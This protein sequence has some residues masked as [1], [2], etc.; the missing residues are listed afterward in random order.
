M[1]RQPALA[2]W[3][4][5]LAVQLVAGLV[6]AWDPQPAPVAAH[7]WDKA[8]HAIAFAL[9]AGTAAFA[10]PGHWRAAAAGLLAYGAL[11]EIGQAFI[12]GRSC[13]AADLLA[14]GVGVA[15]GLAAVHLLRRLL[16]SLR[17][18]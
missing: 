16:S 9:M 4:L 18:G 11:V 14:D 2:G 17:G 13:D 3:R 5:L 15:A 10:W 7:L 1:P 12:P 6:L 8:Q